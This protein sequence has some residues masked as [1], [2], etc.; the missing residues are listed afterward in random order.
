MGNKRKLERLCNVKNI[1]SQKWLVNKQ[2]GHCMMM[3]MIQCKTSLELA[4]RRTV[5]SVSDHFGK[6]VQ[7]QN[8]I[9]QHKT[10]SSTRI[11]TAWIH[12]KRLILCIVIIYILNHIPAFL[13]VE[14]YSVSLISLVDA[15][16]CIRIP[17][18]C[19]VYWLLLSKPDAHNLFL[20]P[21]IICHNEKETE[22][23]A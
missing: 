19:P 5:L 9:S 23:K 7:Q 14:L 3:M 8:N 10:K 21:A 18:S 13:E 22:F 4:C 17:V 16:Q 12:C 2:W 20:T 6:T 1:T 15:M 11:T